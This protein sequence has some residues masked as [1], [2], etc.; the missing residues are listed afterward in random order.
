MEDQRGPYYILNQ[1]RSYEFAIPDHSSKL[2]EHGGKVAVVSGAGPAG[3][4]AAYVLKEKGIKEVIVVE[5]RGVFNRMNFI[6]FEK[7]ALC[8]L[9]EL[10]ILKKFTDLACK[11]HKIY[12]Y[13]YEGD[14][15]VETCQSERQKL[16]DVECPCY[17]AEKM[18]DLFNNESGYSTSIAEL[19]DLLVSLA[20]DKGIKIVKESS[21]ELIETGHERCAV[22]VITPSKTILY[23]DPEY[24]IISEG[25]HSKSV[26]SLNI[27]YETSDYQ[28]A[29]VFG[30]VS[31]EID[32]GQ[33]GTTVNYNFSKDTMDLSNCIFHKGRQELNVALASQSHKLVE[34]EEVAQLIRKQAK[35]ICK[36]H[37]IY[38]KDFELLWFSKKLV[39]IYLRKAQ[40]FIK[41]H[42]VFLVGDAA[43]SGSPLAGLGASL[44]ISAYPY[45]LAKLIDERKSLGMEQSFENYNKRLGAYVDKWHNKTKL[46]KKEILGRQV[47]AR[48]YAKTLEQSSN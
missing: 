40:N 23:K 43:G 26:K 21:I 48:V 47:K 42:N 46:L 19:Q 13:A 1:E 28:E 9:K 10:G 5:N 6:N 4:M 41:G 15:L 29:W 38:S 27:C 45:A 31:A 20:V 8:L 37:S 7:D 18:N 22:K 17:E 25:I 11:I 36:N 35:Q 44:A 16:D 39:T 14:K 3:L 32:L 12:N 30:N 24:V 2:K 33:V 34:K